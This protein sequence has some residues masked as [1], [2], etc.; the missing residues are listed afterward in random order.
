MSRW[1]LTLLLVAAVQV[2]AVA[3]YEFSRPEYRERFQSLSAQLRCPKCIN[4]N[5][6]GSDADIAQD[7]RDE[8]YKQI[9]AGKTDKEIIDFM[10]ARFGH[11]V[12][13]DTPLNKDT[14][15]LWAI[16]A[17]FFLIGFAILI[18]FIS[19]PRQAAPQ[20]LTPQERERLVD[21]LSEHKK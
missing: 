4:Q 7:L 20:E 19:R 8:L 17:S 21:L 10:V 9:E 5:L 18:Y 11:F 3:P 2:F 16:P 12:N 14:W 15:F 6:I 1:Y 13:Y